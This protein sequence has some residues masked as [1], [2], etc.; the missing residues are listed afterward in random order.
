MRVRGKF[1]TALEVKLFGA[2]DEPHAPL[3]DKVLKRHRLVGIALGDGHH[4]PQVCLD[5]LVFGALTL[6]QASL[7]LI[8]GDVRC[9]RPLERRG[10]RAELLAQ[11]IPHPIEKHQVLDSFGQLHL[12]LAREQRH[13]ADILQISLH[14]VRR[15]LAARP[16][17]AP[18]HHIPR[19]RR[20]RQHRALRLVADGIHPR[21]PLFGSAGRSLGP[22]GTAARLR[23]AQRGL[24]RGNTGRRILEHS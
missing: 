4:Q 5:H 14:A 19:A 7:Q 2:T 10:R 15:L 3:L 18:P 22:L 9:A 23:L 6:L 1:V 8:L 20:R 24:A 16:P 11:R 17:H 13:G 12:L 21:L